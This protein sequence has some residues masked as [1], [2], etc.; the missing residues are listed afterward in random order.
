[1][2]NTRQRP[3]SPHLQIYKPQLTSV[4][5]IFH[6]ATGVAL[7]FAL[8]AFVW[9]MLAAA[10]GPDAYSVFTDFFASTIGWIALVGWSF[11]VFYH[12]C[13][14]IRH[15][16]WDSVRL[17]EIKSAERAGIIVVLTAIILTAAFWAYV[18]GV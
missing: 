13:N 17:F 7:V 10:T 12:M 16:I 1:M 14:G 4:L 3:L 18:V 6:R 11:C 2:S 9:M 5:S 8:M 15:L